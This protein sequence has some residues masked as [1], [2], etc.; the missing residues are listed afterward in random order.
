MTVPYGDSRGV[1]STTTDDWWALRDVAP[2][3]GMKAETLEQ[4]AKMPGVL[5]V[6]TRR[7]VKGLPY[8]RVQQG[9]GP[10]VIL[11]AEH[12][13]KLN[14]PSRVSEHNVD[15]RTKYDSAQI[16]ARVAAATGVR[17]FVV[18][19]D[20]VES[21]FDRRGGDLPTLF[22][23][24]RV[25]VLGSVLSRWRGGAGARVIC[26]EQQRRNKAKAEADWHAAQVPTEEQRKESEL[27]E[28]NDLA[29]AP[30]RAKLAEIEAE[31]QAKLT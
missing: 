17:G 7:G 26:D 8:T 11:A 14:N 20:T 18:E 25:T 5:T 31:R 3:W 1:Y 2:E 9:A 16:A 12:L 23:N 4:V 30:M 10:K 13:K 24:G 27:A 28:M 6:E 29:N 22:E 19:T 15:H 21:F